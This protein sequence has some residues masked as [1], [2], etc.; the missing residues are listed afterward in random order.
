MA[1]QAALLF[2]PPQLWA[3]VAGLLA[4]LLLNAA[5]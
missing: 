2:L 5:A 3:A 1:P 4:G